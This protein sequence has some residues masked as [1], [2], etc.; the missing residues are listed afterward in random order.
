MSEIAP[1]SSRGFRPASRRR[2]RLAAGVAL[3]AAAIGGNVLL[4]SSLD[5]KAPA[6]QVVRDVP[7]GELITA[8]MLRTV[9]VDADPT[10]NLVSGTDLGTIVGQYAKVRLVSG[11]LVTPQ[12]LQPGPLVSDGNAVVAILVDDGELPIGIRER[13]PVRL[14]IPGDR[15][16][17]D[18]S[19]R[20][21]DGRVVGLPTASDNGL[22]NISISIELA[23]DDA[24][25]VAA[26]SDV[27][28]VLLVPE[29]DPAAADPGSSDPG[30]SDSG[31]S[32]SGASDSGGS[33]SG[34][35]S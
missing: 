1:A 31:A 24:S 5:T 33:D 26:A 13:V 27:R 12:A 21:A 30:A 28:V 17:A 10:V 2:N 32:D 34:D 20:S 22:G 4:Y 7:A 25:V 16:A 6:V 11:S 19:A 18:S 3:G 14:V 9:D 35:G 29:E 23:T 15:N 8:D